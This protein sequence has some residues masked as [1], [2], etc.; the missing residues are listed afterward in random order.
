MIVSILPG[1]GVM[2]ATSVESWTASSML[3]VSGLGEAQRAL[4]N[5]EAKNT[6][7]PRY[8]REIAVDH[9]FEV[10]DASLPPVLHVVMGEQLHANQHI[11]R[12]HHF[13][14]LE[15]VVHCSLTP[16]KQLVAAK[17]RNRYS[18]SSMSR[19]AG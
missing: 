7:E 19:H 1:R 18:W 4:L 14:G 9:A 6:Q 16:W 15:E 5:V 12:P 8:A 13:A 11:D 2:T 17:R 3:E 10:G